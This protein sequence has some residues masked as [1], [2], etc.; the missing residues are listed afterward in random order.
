[1]SG[2]DVLTMVAALVYVWAGFS[3]AAWRLGALESRPDYSVRPALVTAM[4]LLVSAVGWP[5]FVCRAVGRG[6]RC[7]D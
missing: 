2:V 7:V 4:V 6:L 3:C 5:W 1:M